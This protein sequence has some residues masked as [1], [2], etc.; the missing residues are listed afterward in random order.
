[1]PSRVLVRTCARPSFQLRKDLPIR[2][3]VSM[4][5][6]YLWVGGNR[7][8]RHDVPWRHVGYSSIRMQDLLVQR[9]G[10]ACG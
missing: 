1:M 8:L 4:L 9:L 3:F 5:L 6:L 10:A 2:S 7:I